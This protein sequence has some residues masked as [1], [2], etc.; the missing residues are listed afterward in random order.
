MENAN[1]LTDTSKQLISRRELRAIRINS[2]ARAVQ[3]P[4][5]ARTISGRLIEFAG[6]L[7]AFFLIAEQL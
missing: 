1:M 7:F 4:E 3:E 6:S 2:A 5:T